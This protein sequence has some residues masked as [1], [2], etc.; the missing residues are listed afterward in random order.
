M[1]IFKDVLDIELLDACQKEISRR[2]KQPVWSASQLCWPSN[3]MRN[4][5]GSCIITPVSDELIDPIT[6]AIKDKF[7]P[8]L[9]LVLQFYVW[10]INSGISRHNDNPYRFGA[11]IYL[12][13]GWNIDNGGLFVYN[14]NNTN[15]YSALVP[16]Y[17][18][19]IL[20]DEQEDHLVTPIVDGERHTIQI[21]GK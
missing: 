13:K 11:T 18:V 7:P 20:N 21:W 8:F 1:K 16:T 12:D 5:R 14:K 10:P 4:I 19:M 6:E 17:N 9:E 15:E 3:I 2:K